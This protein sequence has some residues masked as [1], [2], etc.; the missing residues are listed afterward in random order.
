M[1]DEVD[2]W[3]HENHKEGESSNNDRRL[4]EQRY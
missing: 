4:D 1:P 2:R 3:W